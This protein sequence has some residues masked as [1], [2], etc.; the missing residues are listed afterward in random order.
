[1]D[2]EGE[3]L[4]QLLTQGPGECML[5]TQNNAS[6]AAPSLWLIQFLAVDYPGT[7]CTRAWPCGVLLRLYTRSSTTASACHRHRQN[8]CLNTGQFIVP[9][10]DAA[11]GQ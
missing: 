6:A 11:G 1:M 10:G 7:V 3:L 9:A 2:Q 5:V 8:I 4:A